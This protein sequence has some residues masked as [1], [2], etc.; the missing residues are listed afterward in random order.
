MKLHLEPISAHVERS[1]RLAVGPLQQSAREDGDR[2]AGTTALLLI[3][4]LNADHAVLLRSEYGM[5][6]GHAGIKSDTPAP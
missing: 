3:W 4:E 6:T 5:K 1:G 2:A